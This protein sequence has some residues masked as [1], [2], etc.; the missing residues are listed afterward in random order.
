MLDLFLRVALLSTLSLLVS[1]LS[2]KRELESVGTKSRGDMASGN[3]HQLSS[4]ELR[5]RADGGNGSQR[6]DNNVR[7]KEFAGKRED[8]AD[9]E[10][11]VKRVHRLYGKIKFGGPGGRNNHWSSSSWNWRNAL[12]KR[13]KEG[14]KKSKRDDS[15]IDKR[16]HRLY[17]KIK[18]GAQSKP[19]GGSSWNWRSAF[20]NMKREKASETKSGRDNSA[21][22]KRVHH[23]YSS[24]RFGGLGGRQNQ[25][26]AG[27]SWNWRNPLNKM[28]RERDE[29][30]KS[31][32]ENTGIDKRHMYS[33]V[34]FG[35]PSGMW[36]DLIGSH[37]NAHRSRKREKDEQTK[38]AGVDRNHEKRAHSFMY[39]R[40]KFGGRP[41]VG[42]SWN[43]FNSLK[44]DGASKENL[45]PL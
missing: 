12:M 27:S 28:K 5:K 3:D 11:L 26:W 4:L 23:M 44:Q 13:E 36:H 16:V 20:S 2:L 30:M 22:D 10:S 33:N 18:F 34:G 37:S 41:G 38:L 42:L 24:V 15:G 6:N 45:K 19:F 14:N 31:G 7:K 29:K 9:D 1:S 35:G 25:H 17:G 21:I 40:L 39:T 8:Q 32:K 43:P